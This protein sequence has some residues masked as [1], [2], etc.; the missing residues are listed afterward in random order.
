MH[1][2]AKFDNT[3]IY[4]AN[5]IS[6]NSINFFVFL[7]SS[8]TLLVSDPICAAPTEMESINRTS[9]AVSPPS[10]SKLL[11]LLAFAT[12]ITILYA[13]TD[14]GVTNGGCSFMVNCTLSN[15]GTSICGLC[16]LGTS[17]SGVECTCKP[18]TPL[19]SS[20]LAY[21]LF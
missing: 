8:N 2:S 9:C 20:V 21:F 5:T 10:S 13:E 17:G 12:E 6:Y 4:V 16:P 15:T 18:T 11:I 14:C 3:R 1:P 19:L 7:L